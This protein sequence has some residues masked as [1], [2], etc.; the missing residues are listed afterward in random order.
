MDRF[1]FDKRLAK[2]FVKDFNIPIYVIN[3]QLFFIR[4]KPMDICI[5]G[6]FL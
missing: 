3:E 1:D 2:T 4:L 6:T 5:Y